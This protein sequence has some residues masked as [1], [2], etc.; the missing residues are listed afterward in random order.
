LAWKATEKKFNEIIEQL[1]LEMK[2]N[3]ELNPK[4][5]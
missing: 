2:K 5:A 3:N 4:L 1:M